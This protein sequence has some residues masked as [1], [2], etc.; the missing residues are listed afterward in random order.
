MRIGY[1]LAGDTGSSNIDGY[2]VPQ[3]EIQPEVLPSGR[4][5]NGS[6]SKID[7]GLSQ[8][9]PFH[10]EA[11]SFSKETPSLSLRLRSA[12]HAGADSDV[13]RTRSNRF[14]PARSLSQHCSNAPNDNL[15][16]VA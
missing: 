15:S 4:R 6:L 5:W 7:A 13:I 11:T 8:Q 9:G 14:D 2:T 1:M 12:W 10:E 16:V 3:F